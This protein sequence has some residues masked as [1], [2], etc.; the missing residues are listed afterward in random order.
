MKELF[1]PS[2]HV[3]L[4]ND[5]EEGIMVVYADLIAQ[6]VHPICKTVIA[7]VTNLLSQEMLDE[8]FND[9]CPEGDYFVALEGNHRAVAH[10]FLGR[11]IPCTEIVN[12]DDMATWEQLALEGNMSHSF[13]SHRTLDALIKYA[14]RASSDTFMHDPAPTRTARG[15]VEHGVRVEKFSVNTYSPFLQKNIDESLLRPE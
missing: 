7:K 12:D 11:P 13:S 14:F 5:V 1:V 9:S 10:A 8:L 2:S 15:Y 6:G 3:L 4:S